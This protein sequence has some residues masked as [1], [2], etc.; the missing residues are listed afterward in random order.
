[1]IRNIVFDIGNVLIDFCWKEH[2]RGKGFQGE[3]AERI[4]KAM[5]QSPVWDELDRGV[6]TNEELLAGFIAN[7]PQLEEEIRVVFSDLSTIV[8]E[9]EG[10]S[11]WLRSLKARGYRVYYLSNYSRRVKAEAAAELSFLSEMDGGI[12]SCEVQTVKPAPAIY[13]LLFEK[14]GLRP[15]ESVFLDDT[16]ANVETARALGMQGI[17]VRG[18][19]NA[20]QELEKLLEI[21]GGGNK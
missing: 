1:M 13:R 16:R 9:K 4:G 7:D 15:E 10:S 3:T 8:K 17:L 19:E 5:M 14:Y 6:W 18:V 2:I 21:S 11:A 20:K 12:M